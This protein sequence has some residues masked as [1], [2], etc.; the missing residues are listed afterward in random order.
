[1]T[2]TPTN[3]LRALFL[4]LAFSYAMLNANCGG[5]DP[6]EKRWNESTPGERLRDGLRDPRNNPPGKGFNQ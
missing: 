1:M 2:L 5:P 4:A 6:R 3:P